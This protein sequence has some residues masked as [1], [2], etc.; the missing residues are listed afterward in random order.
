MA[1]WLVA[2]IVLNASV[3]TMVATV[4][5][6]SQVTATTEGRGTNDTSLQ[7]MDG[8]Q[9]SDHVQ[10]IRYDIVELCSLYAVRYPS[11]AASH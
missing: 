6:K 9:D 10:A 11:L 7:I 3:T 4:Q 1:D 5:M 2:L 8:V